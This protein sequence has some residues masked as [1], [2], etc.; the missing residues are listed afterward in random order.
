MNLDIRLREPTM[1]AAR[2]ILLILSTSLFITLPALGSSFESLYNN[3]KADGFTDT[4]LVSL[5]KHLKQNR[6]TKTQVRAF[7]DAVENPY[8]PKNSHAGEKFYEALSWYHDTTIGNKNG[9]FSKRELSKV[10][11]SNAKNYVKLLE[12]DVR[13]DVRLASFKMLQKL[14]LIER[15]ILKRKAQRLGSYYP[16][17]KRELG[18]VN[19]NSPWNKANTID[20]LKEFNRRVIDASFVRPVLVKFG[21]TYCVHCLLLENLGSVPAVAK[22]YKDTLDVYKLWWNPQDENY[23]ELNQIANDQGVTSSPYFILYVDGQQTNAGY[24]FPDSEGE[25]MEEFLN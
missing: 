5:F 20:T 16:Y 24:A 1:S 9:K 3:Y 17:R 11:T 4:E 15:E 2:R 6:H 18:Q 13:K 21:L 7:F 23:K 19:P 10:M 14:K 25:G 22:K 12:A 8:A